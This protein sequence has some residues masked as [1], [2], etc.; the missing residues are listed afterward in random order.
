MWNVQIKYQSKKSSNST[1]AWFRNDPHPHF[2]PI[3][4]GLPTTCVKNVCVLFQPRCSALVRPWHKTPICVFPRGRNKSGSQ[5]LLFASAHPPNINM[6]MPPIFP[7][8]WLRLKCRKAAIPDLIDALL[9]LS[10]WNAFTSLMIWEF[11]LQNYDMVNISI[12]ANLQGDRGA[13]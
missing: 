11:V 10:V 8:I 5:L 13:V 12:W 9:V 3:R 7:N 4:F 6:N 1:F 2:I